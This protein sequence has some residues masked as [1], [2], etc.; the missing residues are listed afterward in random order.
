MD[1]DKKISYTSQR[2]PAYCDR[3]LWRSSPYLLVSVLDFWSGEQVSTSDHKPVA[4]LLQL[5]HRPARPSWW[6]LPSELGKASTS[7]RRSQSRNPQQLIVNVPKNF[8]RYLQAWKLSLLTLSGK[9]LKAGDVSGFSD[10]FVCFQGDAVLRACTTE[11]RFQTLNPVWKPSTL[12]V[13]H[14]VAQELSDYYFERIL[15]SVLDFDITTSNDDLGGGVLYLRDYMDHTGKPKTGTLHFD[16]TLLSKGIESGALHG[17]F[18]LESDKFVSTGVFLKERRKTFHADPPSYWRAVARATGI[19][20]FSSQSKRQK[21]QQHLREQRSTM[22]L[23]SE[24]H[25]P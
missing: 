10:P 16:I 12:P 7:S 24:V 1:R 6:P 21:M 18:T 11:A 17:T 8:T 3:V 4:T 2:L 9:G 19:A 23:M 14:I 25:P 13:L 15:V 22:D 5:E 20:C